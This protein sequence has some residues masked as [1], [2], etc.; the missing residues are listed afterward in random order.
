MRFLF[1]LVLVLLGSVACT[2]VDAGKDNVQSN[3]FA[4]IQNDVLV[5]EGTITKSSNLAIFQ[6][7]EKAKEKPKRLIISS[8]GGDVGA[9]MEL[10]EWIHS[11]KLNIEIKNLCL[12]SCANYVLPAGHIKYLHKD[13][14]LMWH[15]SAWQKKWDTTD[16]DESFYASYLP[17]MRKREAAF[18]NRIGV[19]NLITVYGHSE[20]T[21]WDKFKSFFGT[22]LIGWDYSL[23]DIERFGISKII[24]IDN[25]WN[26][27]EYRPR[28]RN[29][30]KRITLKQ[31]YEFMLH[32]FEK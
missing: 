23:E 30:I 29:A 16:S 14:I 18:Y 12:S 7:F 27:R 5:Y 11:N 22:S 15:G 8:P 6:A 21:M 26:W 19:D 13:S 2:S 20:M 3:F 32:R 17:K 1:I 10:G 25:H 24:L 9:G 4:G 28:A 31:N